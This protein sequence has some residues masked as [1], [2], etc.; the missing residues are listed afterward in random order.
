MCVYCIHSRSP[1]TYLWKIIILHWLDYPSNLQCYERTAVVCLFLFL[2]PGR[3]QRTTDQDI[4]MRKIFN[5]PEPPLIL[6]PHACAFIA[7]VIFVNLF[8]IKQKLWLLR[9]SSAR[10]HRGGVDK[11]KNWFAMEKWR[12]R[13]RDKFLIFINH[14]CSDGDA[15]VLSVHIS[16]DNLLLNF[17][18]FM[19]ACR[20]WY[21]NC[22]RRA[23]QPSKTVSHSSSFDICSAHLCCDSNRHSLSLIRNFTVFCINIK[24]TIFN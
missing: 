18:I 15:V 23:A 22:V 10:G 12:D 21:G 9:G 17:I 24:L 11:V 16:I 20:P 7:K 5:A 2:P 14:T 4:A 19:F 6:C 8:K 3:G 13:D 1:F